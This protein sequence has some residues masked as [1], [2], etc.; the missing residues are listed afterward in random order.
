MIQAGSK[1]G[2]N[3]KKRSEAAHI[4]AQNGIYI[5]MSGP[6]RSRHADYLSLSSPIG[7]NCRLCFKGKRK[8]N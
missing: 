5:P 8:G 4:A 7:T 3:S 1:R 2:Y 6:V